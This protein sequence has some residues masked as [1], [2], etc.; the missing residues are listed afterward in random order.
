MNNALCNGWSLLGLWYLHAC[1]KHSCERLFSFYPLNQT[2]Q[3]SF[4]SLMMTKHYS[5]QNKL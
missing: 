1:L 2:N 4:M 5:K 3:S